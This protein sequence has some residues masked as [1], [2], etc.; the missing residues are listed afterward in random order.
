MP[1]IE[2]AH[3]KNSNVYFPF[4]FVCSEMWQKTDEVS[5]GYLD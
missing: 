3:F 5:K 4:Y 2:G 1:Q